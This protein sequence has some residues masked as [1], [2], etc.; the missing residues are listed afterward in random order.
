[1]VLKLFK[2]CHASAFRKSKGLVYVPYF[3]ITK[4]NS[5]GNYKGLKLFQVSPKGLEYFTIAAP[6]Q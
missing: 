2:P 1:M 5:P 3:K 6:A 4:E